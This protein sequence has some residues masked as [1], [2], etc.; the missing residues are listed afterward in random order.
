MTAHQA[1][2][3]PPLRSTKQLIAAFNPTVESARPMDTFSARLRRKG[4]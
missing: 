4:T 2:I 1:A 3:I